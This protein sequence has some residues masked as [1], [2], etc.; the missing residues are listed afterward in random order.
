MQL[1]IVQCL[2]RR[3]SGAA[4]PQSC[5]PI[6]PYATLPHGLGRLMFFMGMSRTSSFVVPERSDASE[7]KVHIKNPAFLLVKKCIS[8]IREI[9]NSYKDVFSFCNELCY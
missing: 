1:R 7:S 6:A 2:S 9:T 8:K 3:S 5:L 4:R